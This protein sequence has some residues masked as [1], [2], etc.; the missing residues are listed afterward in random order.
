MSGPRDKKRPR[1]GIDRKSEGGPRILAKSRADETPEAR[2]RMG[3][4]RT[5]RGQ[6]F[7]DELNAL[8]AAGAVQYAYFE[9]IP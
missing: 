6:S 8:V 9:E 7:V 2:P 4:D 1:L 3:K 5:M